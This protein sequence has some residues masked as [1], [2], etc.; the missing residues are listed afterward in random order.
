MTDFINKL[1]LF[2]RI[3]VWRIR[4]QQ[5]NRSYAYF[6]TILRVLLTAG[7]RFD[8]DKC[9]LKASALTFYSLLSIV[10]VIATLFG[11]AK[12][13]GFEKMLE[14]SL[15][16]RFH[17]Q[18][19]VMEQLLVFSH[20]L[21]EHTKGGVIAGISVLFLIWTVLKLLGHIEEA[22]ND[23]WRIHKQRSFARKFGDYLSMIVV[24][25]ILVVLSSSLTVFIAS[26]W[27]SLESDGGLL[28]HL[29]PVVRTLLK[30]SPYFLISTL[31]AFTYL[32][33]P[34]GK[35]KLSSAIIS[36]LIAGAVYQTAQWLYIYFQV[37]VA[38]YGAVY[39]SF[40]ALPL[41][42]IWMQLSWLIVLAGAELC[43]ASH[44]TAEYEFHLDCS[45][46]SHD[47]RLE[48]AI[49]ITHRS[50]LGFTGKRKAPT[51]WTLSTELGIPIRL[52]RELL[53]RLIQANIICDSQKSPE[54]DHV[55]LPARPIENLRI[56]DVIRAI[57]ESGAG[58]IPVNQSQ[59][60]KE[61]STRLHK[62]GV[63]MAQS[64]ENIRIQDIQID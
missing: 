13:F 55:Y 1:L 9:P 44:N 6:I 48:L 18:S 2:C 16:E 45:Q 23:I 31:F 56:S 36:G 61:I 46:V 30:L 25:P 62:M 50:I 21:L 22:F 54:S 28:S 15:M 63:D 53:H 49:L 10:P 32:F 40:A 38:Q 29:G 51:S 39:G 7:R 12:G 26:Q 27:N 35:T 8:E 59:S 58:S 17:Q 64:E 3:D 47:F 14:R 34:N 37:G 11:I 33:M 41:F 60:Y 24:C 19:E 4:V 43:A 52:T 20:S 57:H 5:T 42:L